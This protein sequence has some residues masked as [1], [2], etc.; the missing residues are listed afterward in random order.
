MNKKHIKQI[1]KLAEK[2]LISEDFPVGAI[3]VKDDKIIGKGY[4]KRNETNITY[5]HAEVLAIKSANKKLKSWRLND[6]DMYVTLEPCEMCKKIIIESRINKVYYLISKHEE[7]EQ[8]KGT[9]F[10]K[11]DFSNNKIDKNLIQNYKES[12]SVF[13]INKR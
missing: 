7:K 2:S 6:C 4:N 5:D 9:D 12:L 3:V 10:K 11:I 8:Y 13:F 1:I